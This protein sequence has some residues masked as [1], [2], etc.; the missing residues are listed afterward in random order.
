MIWA[1]DIK[2]NLPI[3]YLRV[4]KAVKNGSK[5]IVFGHTNTAIAGLA[6]FYFGKDIVSNKF[7]LIQNPNEIEDLKNNIEGKKVT[8][9]A[10]K[11]TVFQ[12]KESLDKLIN[13]LN[14]KSELKVLNSFSKG[15]TFGALQNID[16]VK[17]LN[18][19]CN[20]FDNNAKNI[21]FT[22]GVNPVNSSYFGKKIKENLIASDFVISL[23]FF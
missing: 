6:D 3:L 16:E 12:K 11:S 13:Y 14:E 5:L 19:F 17:G 15:N 10:G 20:E 23:D 4:K 7:E 2:D 1:E 9:I 21:V 8:V 22:I 18:E